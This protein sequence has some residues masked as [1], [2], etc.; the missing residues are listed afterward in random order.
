[1]RLARVVGV[2]VCVLPLLLPSRLPAATPRD[3]LSAR[4]YWWTESTAHWMG[5]AHVSLRLTDGTYLSYWPIFGQR[6]WAEDVEAFG[7]PPAESHAVAPLNEP[8]IRQWWGR[9]PAER[10]CVTCIM[11]A[12]TIGNPRQRWPWTLW[13]WPLPE[14]LHAHLL[15]GEPI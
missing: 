6:T 5:R 15:D 3:A 9:H 13:V 2:F 11:H 7:G 4:L 14:P 1:M 8:A 12:L 10:N